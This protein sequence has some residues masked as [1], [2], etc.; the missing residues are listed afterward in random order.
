M[1][2]GPPAKIDGLDWH[3]RPA[4]KLLSLDAAAARSELSEI[5]SAASDDDLPRLANLLSGNGE[6]LTWRPGTSR[7]SPRAAA[8]MAG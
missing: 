1:K 8:T 4:V 3:L 2:P 7:P 5:A 6:V